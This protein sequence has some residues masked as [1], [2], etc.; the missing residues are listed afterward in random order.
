MQLHVFRTWEK[1]GLRPSLVSPESCLPFLSHSRPPPGLQR[2]NAKTPAARKWK[3]FFPTH[4]GCSEPTLQAHRHGQ[5]RR[6]RSHSG[7]FPEAWRGR[8]SQ[9]QTFLEA[10][11]AKSFPPRPPRSSRLLRPRLPSF[12]R[13]GN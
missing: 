9:E 11:P 8:A 3:P 12:D 5:V 2:K 10:E 1:P 6:A 4:C 13:W 7:G